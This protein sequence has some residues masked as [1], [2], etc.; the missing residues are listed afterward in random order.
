[1]V[2]AAA[3]RLL[4]TLPD[5]PEQNSAEDAIGNIIDTTVLDQKGAGEALASVEEKE[6]AMQL[7]AKGAYEQALLAAKADIEAS[8]SDGKAYF[9]AARASLLLS[10]TAAA[11]DYSLSALANGQATSSTYSG[12]GVAYIQDE[13][14]RLADASFR[15]AAE[16][17]PTSSQVQFNL[18]LVSEVGKDIPRASDHYLKAGNL[19]LRKQELSRVHKALTALKR[20]AQ[21]NQYAQNQYVE[22]GHQVQSALAN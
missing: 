6:S 20:L 17:D 4:K 14:W 9:V 18:A 11:I 10:D 3:R 22:L 5:R 21:N 15:K 12:L 19:A 13:N 8:G 7:L 2:D 16:L 1:M